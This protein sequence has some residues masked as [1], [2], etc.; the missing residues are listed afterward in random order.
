MTME[1]EIAEMLLCSALGCTLPYALAAAA[2]WLK[3]HRQMH[4]RGVDAPIL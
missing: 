2:A 4:R 1:S 3:D